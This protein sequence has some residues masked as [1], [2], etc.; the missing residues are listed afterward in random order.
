M[1]ITNLGPLS[2][3]DDSTLTPQNPPLD[4]AKIKY[5]EEELPSP[6]EESGSAKGNHS[7]D[8]LKFC[9]K[10]S[11][12]LQ[13]RLTL[14]TPL[15][16]SILAFNSD[17]LVTLLSNLELP[18]LNSDDITTIQIWCLRTLWGKFRDILSYSKNKKICLVKQEHWN[19]LFDKKTCI[20]TLKDISK[21]FSDECKDFEGRAFEARKVIEDASFCEILAQVLF[22]SNKL[23]VMMV[24]LKDPSEKGVSLRELKTIDNFFLMIQKADYLSY[25][26]HSS[27]K[28][29]LE[30]CGKCKVCK[31]KSV[32]EDFGHGL[33]D[34]RQKT[35][36]IAYKIDEMIRLFSINKFEALL[37]LETI[38]FDHLWS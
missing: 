28:F 34:A 36:S 22:C 20:E 12:L 3:S 35:R 23:L 8:C 27:G 33:I 21:K 16:S 7:R 29:A 26:N 14:P 19:L 11:S 31:A 15:M 6:K 37:C 9:R 25:Y 4:P 18:S 17:L 30:C 2:A 13:E 1:E 10:L 5:L 38:S 32:P 24:I